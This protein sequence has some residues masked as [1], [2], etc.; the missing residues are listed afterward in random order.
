MYRGF[1]PSAI[2]SDLMVSSLLLR[3]AGA[4][5][6]ED[7]CQ[8]DQLL[9]EQTETTHEGTSTTVGRA[10]IP[11]SS[12][13]GNHPWRY[14]CTTVGQRYQQPKRHRM[15]AGYPI[16]GTGY[17]IPQGSS[18]RIPASSEMQDVFRLP[19]KGYRSPQ[20]SCIRIPAT[21]EMRRLPA[22]QKWIPDTVYRR[23]SCMYK[24][25]DACSGGWGV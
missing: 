25:W 7:L 2:A 23:G 17:C 12:A 19:N 10:A 9:P 15:S 18:V 11:A 14:E 24:D 16:R 21:W 8:L 22:N 1:V 5:S 20:G 13:N 3:R 4:D 6:T